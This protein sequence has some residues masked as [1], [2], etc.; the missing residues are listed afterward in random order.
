MIPKWDPRAR[1]GVY[2]GHSPCHAGNVA[3]IL[4]LQTG[5]ISPQFHV[6][7][8]EGFSTVESLRADTEPDNWENLVLNHSE[9]ATDE[10]FKLSK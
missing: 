3:L 1:V 6:T 9:S 10:D 4:N 2:L 8:D 7:F 5:H